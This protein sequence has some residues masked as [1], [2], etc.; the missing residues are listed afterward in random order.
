MINRNIGQSFIQSRLDG[1]V[2]G[3]ANLLSCP[4]A[5]LAGLGGLNPPQVIL[6]CQF[7]KYYRDLYLF[8][9]P[10]LEVF[11]FFIFFIFLFFCSSVP[12]PTL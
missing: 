12:D 10:E 3:E 6:A 2:R 4:V 8:G 1:M 7:E 9:D 11:Y 5:G